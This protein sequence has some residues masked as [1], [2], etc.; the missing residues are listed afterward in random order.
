M[1]V[2]CLWIYHHGLPSNSIYS[3]ISSPSII[4]END[5]DEEEEDDYLEALLEK[6]KSNSGAVHVDNHRKCCPFRGIHIGSRQK[7]VILVIVLVFV[8]MIAFAV[9]I[10]VG[11]GKNHIDSQVAARVY[12]DLFAVAIFLL[13]GALACYG[14]MLCLKMSKVKSERASSEMWKVAGLAIVSLVCFTSCALVAMVTNIPLPY[15]WHSDDSSGVKTS[16]LIM[17]YYFIGSSIPSA[18]VLWVMREMP[19]QLAVN[20]QT[21]TRVVTFIRDSPAVNPHPQRWTAATSSQNQAL[22]VSPI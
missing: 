10:W 1:L 9:L 3:S 13:G 18:F 20:R 4:L 8:L 2:A 6:T 14:L 15:A 11:R 22:K 7:F 19:P 16:L 21:Q 5:E 17:L 12:L